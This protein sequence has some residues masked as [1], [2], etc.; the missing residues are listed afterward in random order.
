MNCKTKQN[1]TMLKLES[2][3][4]IK[5]VSLWILRG[6]RCI[7]IVMSCINVMMES[8]NIIIII[9]I[10]TLIIGCHLLHDSWWVSCS[11]VVWI[12]FTSCT[13]GWLVLAELMG[14]WK[15][16]K[17]SPTVKIDSEH[18]NHLLFWFFQHNIIPTTIT[19][20]TA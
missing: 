11:A 4:Q 16:N 1:S 9:L 20:T 19:R 18:Y 14:D 3:V 15:S 8:H 12:T 6:K 2:Y 7:I 5:S 13:C 10:N 17:T